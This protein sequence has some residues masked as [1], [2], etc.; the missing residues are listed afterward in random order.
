[1]EEVMAD[2][3]PDKIIKQVKQEPLMFGQ[4]TQWDMELKILNIVFSGIF[5]SC[6]LQIT[7]TN[8]MQHQII[9]I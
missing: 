2:C 9:C 5:Q 8:C 6:F 7:R 4:M 1:M 3:L